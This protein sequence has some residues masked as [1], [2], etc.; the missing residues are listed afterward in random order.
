MLRA[1]SSVAAALFLSFRHKNLLA[2]GIGVFT[3]IFQLNAAWRWDRRQYT[4]YT[5]TLLGRC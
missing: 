4:P 3:A 5:S 2:L 1:A